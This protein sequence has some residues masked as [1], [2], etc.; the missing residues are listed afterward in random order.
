MS[1]FLKEQLVLCHC[2]KAET[3]V[4]VQ[5]PTPW[6]KRNMPAGYSPSSVLTHCNEICNPVY[7]IQRTIRQAKL[8]QKTAEIR[9]DQC[10]PCRR[11]A[12]Q[13]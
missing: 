6:L 10:S 7:I 13:N 1:Q 4:L 12:Y 9:L 2:S 3:E 5:D 11:C 8:P